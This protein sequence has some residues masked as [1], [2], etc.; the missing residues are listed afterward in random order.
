MSVGDTVGFI[1]VFRYA[2]EHACTKSMWLRKE[3]GAVKSFVAYAISLARMDGSSTKV[4]PHRL[5]RITID[6]LPG[7]LPNWHKRSLAS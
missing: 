4:Q 2:R 7:I 6:G 1:G 3:E 5:P